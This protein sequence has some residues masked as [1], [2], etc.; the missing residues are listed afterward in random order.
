MTMKWRMK[1][2]FSV[3]AFEIKPSRSRRLAKYLA[4]YLQNF[5]PS[6]QTKTNELIEF[7]EKPDKGPVIVYFALSCYGKPREFATLMLYQ[8]STFWLERSHSDRTNRTRLT[9]R[10]TNG[11]REGDELVL[12]ELHRS[13]EFR[14]VDGATKDRCESFRCAEQIDVLTDEAGIDGC[15]ET[16]VL[17]RN[18]LHP[19]TMRDVD[20][21]ER[22]GAQKILLARLC[23]DVGTQVRQQ[24]MLFRLLKPNAIG[25][26]RIDVNDHDVTPIRGGAITTGTIDAECRP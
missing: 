11:L 14:V 19:L 7:Q 2:G 20:K 15:I 10:I 18:I 1:S 23:A 13:V 17:R 24:G 25:Q 16:A 6:R 9:P 5:A 3:D 4:I 22:D 12:P 8:D 21:I 26:R